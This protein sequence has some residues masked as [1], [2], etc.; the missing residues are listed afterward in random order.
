[1]LGRVEPLPAARADTIRGNTITCGQ[2][3]LELADIGRQCLR[4]RRE[5]PETDPADATVPLPSWT[6]HRLEGGRGLILPGPDT[7]PSAFIAV[8]D[9][10]GPSWTAE[11]PHGFQGCPNSV[12]PLRE[13]SSG[14]RVLTVHPWTRSCSESPLSPFRSL[15]AKEVPTDSRKPW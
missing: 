3:L 4:F 7:I 11:A 8:S 2:E 13:V 9:R 10:S 6:P 15:G 5:L 12:L 1:M 14:F